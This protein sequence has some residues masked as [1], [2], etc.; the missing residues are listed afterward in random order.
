MVDEKILAVAQHDPRYQRIND[1]EAVEPHVLKEIEQFFGV[2]E[3]LENKLS[4]TFGWSER[5]EA[6]KRIESCRRTPPSA[7][8]SA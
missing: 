7:N 2:Y 8:G 3:T 1:L 5:R 6:C 4:L